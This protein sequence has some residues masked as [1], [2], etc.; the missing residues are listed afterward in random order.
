MGTQITKLELVNR[1]SE[2]NDIDSKAAAAR[3]LDC[4]IDIITTEVSSGKQV[5]LG[6]KF[7]KF[8]PA[9]RSARTGVSSFDGKPYNSPARQIIKYKPSAKMKK[10]IKGN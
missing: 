4:L 10:A 2:L 9:I 7:G 6:N 3:I 1:L 5:I 8:V